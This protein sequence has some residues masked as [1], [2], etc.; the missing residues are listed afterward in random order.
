[1]FGILLLS[2]VIAS[3]ANTKLKT[4][5]CKHLT[6]LKPLALVVEWTKQFGTSDDDS[7]YSITND[8]NGNI[9]VVGATYGDLQGTNRGSSDAFV[10]KYSPSSELLWTRPIWYTK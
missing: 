10:S 3:N 7:A 2:T 9:Y 1:M 5:E 6:K 4:S 8:A